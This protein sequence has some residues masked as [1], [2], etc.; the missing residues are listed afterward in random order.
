[1]PNAKA[2]LTTNLFHSSGPGTHQ[3]NV[4]AGTWPEDIDGDVLIVGPNKARPGGHWFDSQGILTRIRLR[5]SPASKAKHPERASASKR[6]TP[7]TP[8][9]ATIQ[10]DIREV[11]TPLARLRKR[12]PFLFKKI[13]FIE[14]SPFGISNLANTNVLTIDDRIFI[15]YDAGRPVEVD[16]DTLQFL[17]PVGS[18]KEWVH[19]SPAL[20]EPAIAVA[21]HA[22]PDFDEHAL[23]F[24]NYSMLPGKRY[25]SVA[26]WNLDGAIDRWP[27]TTEAQFDSIH[28][29]KTTRDYVI[30]SDLPFVVEPAAIRNK[31]RKIKNQNHTTLFIIA[32]QDLRNTSPGKHVPVQV[33][34]I[35]IPTGHIS[36]EYENPEGQCVINLEHI[37]ITDLMLTVDTNSP[38][39][40]TGNTPPKDLDGMVEIGVQPLGLGRYR[41]DATSGEILESNIIWDDHVWGS[42]V[43][44]ADES[45]PQ[46]RSDRRHLW[47]AALG[48][49]PDLVSK[50][51][52][53]LYG[54][55][56][57]DHFVHPD[58]LP[59]EGRPPALV[60]FNL[61]AG[62]ISDHYDFPDGSFASPATFVP[63]TGTTTVGDGY[64]VVM[65][66]KDGDK[67]VQIFDAHR[68]ADGPVA[69]ASAPGFCPPLQLHSWWAPP[70]AG[71]TRPEY[72]VTVGRDIAGA[73]LGLPSTIIRFF[74]GMAFIRSELKKLKEPA[75]K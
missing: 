60:H 68:L 19:T 27:L 34:R 73:V 65:V 26:R 48:F 2:P 50:Q 4:I 41:I 8:G 6:N 31:G 53:D 40:L 11:A 49:H 12:V 71:T 13:R 32:K 28:D 52:F 74:K 35:P 62:T 59:A 51:W 33:V 45:T 20:Y 16:R 66:H 18:T 23:Y 17:T 29:V 37:A 69:R 21:A 36:V 1:M 46:A 47:T 63:R 10:V 7:S 70:H 15:G 3:L 61:E 24:A 72:Q 22:A 58:N 42:L 44:T 39:P 67:E 57:N 64:I 38:S 54:D 55:G 75:A 9:T 30:I 56:T 5:P 43:Y 25:L 14:L